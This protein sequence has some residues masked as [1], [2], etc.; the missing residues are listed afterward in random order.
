MV[1]PEMRCCDEG[2]RE[3]ASL[4]VKS[5]RCEIVQSICGLNIPEDPSLEVAEDGYVVCA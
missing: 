1:Y 3:R 5:E 4:Q 2:Y